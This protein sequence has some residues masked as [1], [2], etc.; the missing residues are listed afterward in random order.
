MHKY[1]ITY[2]DLQNSKEHISLFAESSEEA[3]Q[4]VFSLKTIISIRD[5]GKVIEPPKIFKSI[6]RLERLSFRELADILRLLAYTKKAGLSITAS[7]ETLV[8]TGSKRQVLFCS[9]V[10][11]LLRKG[12]SLADS[13][14]RYEYMLPLPISGVLRSSSDSGNLYEI[15]LNL[16]EQLESNVTTTNKIKTAMIYP[17]IVL[18]VALAVAVFLFTGIIPEVADILREL[19][20]SELPATTQAVLNV[21]D[22]FERY[23][24]L[25]LFG[26]TFTYVLFRV[27]CRKKYSL[28]HSRFL[29]KAPFFRKIVLPGELS[30]FYG[31]F[32]FLLEAG[33]PIDD[34]LLSASNVINNLYLQ[35]CILRAHTSVQNGFSIAEAMKYTHIADDITLQL[36]HTGATSGN[37]VGVCQTISKQQSDDTNRSI[38]RLLKILEPIIMLVVG[39]I[40]GVI[41]ISVYQPLFEMMTVV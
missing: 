37:L 41:M 26:L 28:I 4:R 33:F 40:V 17:V 6:F 22:F 12:A 11:E 16:A 10:L 20:N 34:A 32:A 29:V 36:L 8:T 1:K 30:K 19:G 9:R 7:F 39:A 23:G 18:V 13:I 2:L 24:L 5:C 25:I 21:G 3:I 14:Q 38:A 31:H 15:L 35:K 27:V